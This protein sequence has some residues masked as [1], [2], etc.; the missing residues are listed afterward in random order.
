MNGTNSEKI[1]AFMEAVATI[2]QNHSEELK[3]LTARV[4]TLEDEKTNWR[5]LAA[6][7]MKSAQD[8]HN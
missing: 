7:A 8:N 4:K 2:L 6:E 5:Q 1:I 3:K